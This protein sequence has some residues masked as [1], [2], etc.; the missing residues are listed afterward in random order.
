MSFDILLV[1]MGWV[2]IGLRSKGRVQKVSTPMALP[3]PEPRSYSSACRHG[4][5]CRTERFGKAL[6]VSI[7]IHQGPSY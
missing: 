4:N 7:G 6:L 1:T 2:R 5:Q 3:G